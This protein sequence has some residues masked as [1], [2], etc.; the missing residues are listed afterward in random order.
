MNKKIEYDVNLNIRLSRE[1]RD[2]LNRIANK[3]NIKQSELIRQFI[4]ELKE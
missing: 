2:K 1:L 4:R 3:H